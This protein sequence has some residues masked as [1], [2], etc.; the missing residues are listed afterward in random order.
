M[1]EGDLQF[2]FSSAV[3]AKRFDDKDHGLSH[4]MKAVDFIVE[5]DKRILS[6]EIK[7]FQHPGSRPSNLTQNLEK[8]CSETLVDDELTP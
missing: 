4:C 1:K 7:D 6:I 8:L 2:N 5:E 3:S